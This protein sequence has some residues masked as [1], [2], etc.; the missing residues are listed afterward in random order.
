MLRGLEVAHHPARR[1]IQRPHNT[2]RHRPAQH[3]LTYVTHKPGPPH[4]LAALNR[5]TDVPASRVVP[6]RLP[7]EWPL[8]ALQVDVDDGLGRGVGGQGRVLVRRHQDA[9]LVVLHHVAAAVDRARVAYSRQ[10]GWGRGYGSAS[11]RMGEQRMMYTIPE[12]CYYI[13][14]W[15]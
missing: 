7:D 15:H 1:G 6:V 5:W 11:M 4:S 9:A 10:E 14:L 12:R 13:S 2:R 3:N 8:C